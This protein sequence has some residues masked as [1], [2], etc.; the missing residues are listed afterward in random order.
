MAIATK[1]GCIVF[2]SQLLLILLLFISPSLQQQRRD[3]P[4]V[5]SKFDQMEEFDGGSYFM[6][7]TH[8]EYEYKGEHP[9]RQEYVKPFAMDRYPVTNQQF[10]E[11]VYDTKFFRTDPE[12]K[13]FS[14]VFFQHMKQAAKLM[15]KYKLLD[16]P[17]W[18][19]IAGARWYQ[20]YGPESSWKDGLANHP[21][22]HIGAADA[23][24]YCKWKG[25]RLP[26]EFEWEYAARANNKSWIYPW[27]DHYRKMRMNTW[28]GLFPYENMGFDGHK[29][30]APVDAYPQQNHRDMYD[31]L[32]NTWEWTS[33]EYYGSDRP[34][35]KVWLILKGGS[36]VDSIDEGINTIV[37]TSTKIGREI[38]FTAENIGFR[39][40]R[41]IIPKP[42]VKPQRV[43]R[44]EDTWEYKQSQKEKKARLEK[45]QKTQKVNVKQYRFEL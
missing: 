15:E 3:V 34:P 1:R 41:T 14:Y 21:A 8:P 32:G 43:I 5:E 26:T 36:F 38:D 6:G 45:L 19:P 24:S 35:G 42:E 20:P 31:M 29:G 7:V 9:V 33:T 27:G 17:W 37:R 13:G 44:L 12:L 2:A 11:F 25:K 30:L 16:E 28:Q 23:D 4:T 39:C 40:A 10:S 22:V 18:L